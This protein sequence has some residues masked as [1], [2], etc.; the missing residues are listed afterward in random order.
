MCFAALAQMWGTSFSRY[1]SGKSHTN[2]DLG[3]FLR[4]IDHTG[5]YELRPKFLFSF[6]GSGREQL[7]RCLEVTAVPFNTSAGNR[8]LAVEEDTLAGTEYL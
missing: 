1:L 2:L 8:S 5:V 4:S 7:R 3:T 6:F